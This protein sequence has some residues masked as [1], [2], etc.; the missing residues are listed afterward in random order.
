L[1][2]TLCL[3]I[4]VLT[5]IIT[6]EKKP[7]VQAFTRMVKV[8]RQGCTGH[9]WCM[10]YERRTAYY[11]SYRQVYR[12]DFKTTYKC[13]R[14]WSQFNAEAGCL[15]RKYF[16]SLCTYGVCF[17]GAVCTGHLNQLCDCPAGFNGS[18]CQY[19]EHTNIDECQ[20]HNG[21]CQHRCVNTRGSVYCECNP[22]FRL[23]IDGRTC[24]AVLSCAVNNGGCEHECVQLSPVHFQCRC[25]R[26]SQLTADRKNPCAERN[27]GCVHLCRSDGGH[28]V[29]SCHQGF[30]LAPDQK[31]CEDV[32]ECETGLA[33]CAHSCRN[34]PGSFSCICNPGYELGSDGRKCYRIE[35]EIVNSCDSD[36]GGCSHHC[37]H[38]TLGPVCSCNQG[39]QLV[40]DRKTC[41][42]L[43]E[44]EEGTSCCEQDCTNY[45]GGYE[46]YCR[47]GYRLNADGCGCDALERAVEELS[48][49]AV[50][51]RPLL[52]LTLLQ[53]YPQPLE[54]YHDYEDDDGFGELRADSTLSEKFGLLLYVKLCLNGT[55]GHDCSLTCEDCSNG[56]LC[57]IDRDGC[58]CPDGWT[59]I[60][61]NQSSFYCGQHPITINSNKKHVQSIPSVFRVR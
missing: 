3:N 10:D 8:W 25:R 55:F 15:Y 21:G 39:Y 18:S 43:E 9:A 52:H 33:A 41:L 16:H 53:D 11:I 2:T 58:D 6:A 54:L 48:S 24:I 23:H 13:C 38:D 32:D 57:N 44:C 46:C 12:Q 42:D 59:A 51:E 56:G 45:P 26:G 50:V 5:R 29:C 35:I 36:N 40:E 31:N 22:G 17:N 7:C 1:T 4:W 60:I 27:G 28:A 34:T 37:Q 47:A 61:C 20:V 30:M 14:G 49:P 19:D